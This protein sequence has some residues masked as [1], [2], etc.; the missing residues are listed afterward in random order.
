MRGRKT[1]G[2]KKGTPN[3]RTLL[4]LAAQQGAASAA[5]GNKDQSG[6]GAPP[7]KFAL[8]APQAHGLEL[9]PNGTLIVLRGLDP[10]AVML[11]GMEW[12]YFE[13]V[14][15]LREIYDDPSASPE[16]RLGALREAR[17]MRQMA[18]VCA[19]DAAPYY[20]PRLSAKAPPPDAPPEQDPTKGPV[21]KD[22]SERISEIVARFRVKRGTEPAA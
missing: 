9:L 6:E 15:R 2:R 4:R 21:I 5:R 10:V 3:K 8:P 11:A 1:G 14:E 12:A 13:A 22:H 20:H 19:T 16:T 7:R 17:T 18:H